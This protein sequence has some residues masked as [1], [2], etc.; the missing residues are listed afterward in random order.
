ML[1]QSDEWYWWPGG[2]GTQ[3][4]DLPNPAK[5]AP[6]GVGGLLG[7]LGM[8]A[9]ALSSRKQSWTN[10]YRRQLPWVS[11]HLYDLYPGAVTFKQLRFI[12]SLYDRVINGANGGWAGMKKPLRPAGWLDL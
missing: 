1:A 11:T 12:K 7:P 9:G 5:L 8:A 6:I 10:H 2:Y 3:K 4:T